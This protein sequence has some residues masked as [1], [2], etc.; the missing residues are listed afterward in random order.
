MKADLHLHS[1]ASDGR[2][3]ADELVRQAARAGLTVIAL[4]DHD[5]VDGVPAALAAAREFP[6][7]QVIPGVE[8]GTD[9]PHGEVHVLGYFVDYTSRDLLDR[10]E[11]LRSGR[12]DR[13]RRMV[14]KLKGL[15]IEIEW[16]RV[17]ELAG[18]GAIGRPHVAQA[19]YEM[20]YISS[21]KE[22]F[23][24]YIGR[25]GPAYAEREKL[26]PVGAVELV[27]KAKGLPVLAHPG[28]IESLDKLLTELKGA[29]L[30]G[31]EVYYGGYPQE[32]VRSLLGVA[33][34]YDLIPCGGSDYHGLDPLAD[35]PLGS[36]DVPRQFVERL[37]ALSRN[38][39]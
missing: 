18:D 4:T 38:R 33:K 6:S 35:A 34:R 10:L 15:G 26:T 25:D 32:T 9:V 14:D 7:L 37:L 28:D 3:P 8:I 17:Q 19:M 16:D 24:K 27:V 13:A 20:G 11:K 30:V 39:V 5:S 36:V 31:I 12:L 2:L 23:D 29:G 1:N 21:L 22:A